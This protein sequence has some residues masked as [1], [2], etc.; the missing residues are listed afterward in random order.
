VNVTRSLARYVA[1]ALA[2]FEVRFA[3]DEA[4]LERPFALVTEATPANSTPHGARHR[5][6]RQSFT[7]VAYPLEGINA[8]SSMIEAKRVERLLL[9]AF[10]KG[11]DPVGFRRGT[12][13]AHPMRVP[14]VHY[15]DVGV[16][17]AATDAER[18][19]F[20]RVVEPPAVS[21]FADPSDDRVYIVACDVRLAWS[22]YVGVPVEGALV[23]R[24]TAT[25]VPS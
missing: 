10:A 17:E 4:S 15:T 7:V 20:M 13:R 9:D 5:E 11:I 3:A 19:G 25:P 2:D 23:E 22:E 18:T 12:G 24:V 8:E 21:V 6:V 1:L 14:L 16:R